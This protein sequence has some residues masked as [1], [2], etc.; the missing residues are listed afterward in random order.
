LLKADRGEAGEGWPDKKICE[1]LDTNISLAARVRETFANRGL[2][3][4]HRA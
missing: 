1:A 2:E 4:V 3:A